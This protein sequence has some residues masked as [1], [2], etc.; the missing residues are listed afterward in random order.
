MHDLS[1]SPAARGAGLGR[2]LLEHSLRAA[3]RLGLRHS[4]LVAV[5]GAAGYWA[6]LGYVAVPAS[7]ALAEKLR[8]YGAG[9]V[10]M[11]RVLG[12]GDDPEA[13]AAGPARR[14]GTCA[15]APGSPGT[16]RP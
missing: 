1:V 15:A 4:E 14:L 5:P 16:G 3:S 7:E 6:R 8:G 9:A 13:D 2:G 10:Y 12:E 11:R